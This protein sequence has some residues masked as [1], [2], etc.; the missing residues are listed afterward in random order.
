MLV[1]SLWLCRDEIIKKVVAF[2]ARLGV[3]GGVWWVRYVFLLIR[4]G[5][6]VIDLW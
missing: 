3:C 5:I 2:M 1:S 4:Y 6:G